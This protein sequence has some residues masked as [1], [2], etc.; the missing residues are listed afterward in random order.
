M[1]KVVFAPRI[2]ITLPST[3]VSTSWKV[4]YPDNKVA[5]ERSVLDAGVGARDGQ[6]RRGQGKRA[7]TF[8]L[9]V[10]V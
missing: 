4:D 10:L 9:F 6:L 3:L 2:K 7:V 1:V 8:L 5:F